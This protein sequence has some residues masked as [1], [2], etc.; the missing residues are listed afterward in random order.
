M[1]N[2]LSFYFSQGSKNLK[3]SVLIILGLSLALSMVSGI[4]LYVDAYQ[5][6]LVNESFNQIIDFNMAYGR[7]TYV[8]NISSYFPSDDSSVISIVQNSEVLD[9]ESHFRYFS[10]STHDLTYYKNYS[11]LYGTDFHG[12]N[13]VDEHFANVGLF[14]D[15]FY[16]S[17]RFDN[18]FSIIN[19]TFPKS[20]KEILVPIDL[21]YKM[22]LTLGETMNLDIKSA[23]SSEPSNSSLA[24]SD[25]KV[26]GIYAAKHRFYI[27][28]EEAWLFN[29]YTYHSENNT[30]TG[31]DELSNNRW[32]SDFVFCYYNF[33]KAENNNHPVQKLIHDIKLYI[34]NASEGEMYQSIYLY[35]Q[36]GLAFCYNRDNIDFKH[37]NS[38][39]RKI[40]QE[41]QIIER[42]LITYSGS[43][44][45][46]LSRH[47]SELY[48]ESNVF[49]IVLQILNVPI[50]IFAI[51]IGSFAIKTNAKSRLDEFL[52]LRSKGAPNSLLRNQFFIEALFNGIA[53]STVALIAGFGTFYGFR[54][55]LH[56]IFFD[57]SSTTI[58]SPTISWG[59]VIL[60]YSLGIGIT[61]LASFSSIAYVGKLPTYK[62]LTILGS[63]A[64]DVEYDEKS[65]FH[66]TEEKTISLEETPFYEQSPDQESKETRSKRIKKRQKKHALYQNA[67]QTK[68]KKNPKLSIAFIIISL[69]PLIIYLLYLIGTLPFAAD[70]FISLSFYIERFFGYILMFAVLSPVLFVVG[71]IRVLIVEKPTRFA[72]I[73][74]FISSIFLKDRS[75]L[76]GIEMVKRKQYR[77]VIFLVGIFTSLLVFTNVFLNSFS[78]YDIMVSNMYVGSDV[79]VMYTNEG[80]SIANTSDAELLESQI[81]SYK[82]PDNETLIN[83]VL[84]GYYSWDSDDYFQGERYFFDIEK[85]LDI[86][87]E[88]NKKLPTGDFVSNIEDL[89][90]YNKNPSNIIPGVIVNRGF[91]TLNNVEV[92]DLYEITHSYYNSTSMIYYNVSTSVKIMVS[93]DI[94]PGI[95]LL[96][97]SWGYY[98]EKMIFDIGS[99]NQDKNLL[100]GNEIFQMIDIDT[101]V[102]EDH[103]KL[104]NMLNNATIGYDVAYIQIYDQNWNDLNYKMEISE[105]GFYGIIY[106]EFLMIGV[107]LAFGLAILILSFQ[108][109]NKY[110]NG[111]LLARGF[112]R[113]GLLKLILS[114]ISIIFLIGI[115]TGLL[116]GFLTSFSFLKI[117]TVMNYGAGMFSFPLYVNALEL[118]E[119][120]GMI[121]LS[122]FVIYLIAYYFEAKKNIT[123]YFHKF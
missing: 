3:N 7:G 58:L 72:K 92:G 80:M 28:G 102:E 119:I 96:R 41:T 56:E 76:C 83:D 107:L 112:G 18:Y 108:R 87:R 105:S 73:S 2:R 89:I 21:A 84:T 61:F 36:A 22:N 70:A 66:Q 10:L 100:H 55:L 97:S 23:W 110:F 49:R 118:V 78:R 54:E 60:T 75:F 31:Y 57:Y 64:M 94:M 24:L 39:S 93:T 81:K 47:L 109:E 4:S 42:Q 106:L 71:I 13:I 59:T 6:N 46:F 52:L 50:L 88:D 98:N 79:N 82:T 9:I 37:L 15:D 38:F 51:F 95:Y 74:K 45:D 86:I 115:L 77:T 67:V 62:L 120:L 99:V 116:S 5:N 104:R 34:E 19:G 26:V 11:Q 68:E 44:Q 122:S 8:E 32:A 20:D 12:Y 1:G 17:K 48:F 117:A 16:T 40:A 85:Y 30:V 63:D 114:Q 121:V 43:F 91:L 33:S 123:Q 53:S 69:F 113:L 14:D 27:F 35:K 25:V 111:V 101:D 29:Q 90:E 65:L 103:E